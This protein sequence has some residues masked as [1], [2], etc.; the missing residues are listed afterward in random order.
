MLT[1]SNR[2]SGFTLIE[3]LVVIAII[4]LLIGIP[5]PALGKARQSAKRLQD[6]SNIR[7][8]VQGFATFSSANRGRYPQPSRIDNANTTINDGFSLP[9]GITYTGVAQNPQVKDTSQNIFSILIWDSF[10]QPEVLISPVEQSSSFRPDNDYQLSNPQ[11]VING[12]NPGQGGGQP[13]SLALWD[14]AFMSSPTPQ[15]GAG[16]LSY[17]H[18]P[19]FGARRSLWR[20]NFDATQA[21]VGN[22]GPTYLPRQNIQDPWQLETNTSTGDGSITLLMHGNR[23]R[24]EG[25][26]GYNDAHVNFANDAAP[27]NLLFT[28][29]G[30]NIAQGFQTQPDNVFVNENDV[31]GTMQVN[32][33]DLSQLGANNRNAFLVMYNTVQVQ[34]DQVVLADTNAQQSDSAI[35]GSF[36][37]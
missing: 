4:A 8:V 6:S 35:P 34:G 24:W 30:D 15:G 23:T 5:L 7:S 27:E 12:G 28:F 17:F 19:I 10:S 16:N 2:R 18:M 1:K 25:L 36:H 31:N 33:Q 21:L 9:N 13:G 20:D 3:L 29:T 22:R 26:I 37:D 32:E 11:A 14:P